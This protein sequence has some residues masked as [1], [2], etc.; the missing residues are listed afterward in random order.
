M[1]DRDEALKW[2]VIGWSV[3]RTCWG[4]SVRAARRTG[5]VVIHSL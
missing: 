3:A 2:P 5:Q 1:I 4:P